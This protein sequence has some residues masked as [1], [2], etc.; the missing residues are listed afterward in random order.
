MK[1]KNFKLIDSAGKKAV[2]I[3]CD[4]KSAKNA[5]EYAHPGIKVMSIEE[6]IR[7]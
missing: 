6:D 5:W 2:I 4:K 7:C 1:L 3:A